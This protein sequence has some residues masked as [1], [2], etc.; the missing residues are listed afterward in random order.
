E[1]G[2]RQRQRL[3]T[4]ISAASQ[5]GIEGSC[6]VGRPAGKLTGAR[7]RGSERPLISSD[8]LPAER[9]RPILKSLLVGVVGPVPPPCTGQNP[10]GRAQERH[11]N[12]LSAR[13]RGR[14]DRHTR[15]M[16]RP[17]P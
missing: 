13:E 16:L 8:V 12:P 10:G 14:C 4:R 3:R 5:I 9:A 2:E 11:V 7:R 17:K 6:L 15:N 1:S